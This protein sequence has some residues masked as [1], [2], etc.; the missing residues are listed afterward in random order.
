MIPD[1]PGWEP[2]H[3]LEITLVC[4]PLPLAPARLPPQ[5]SPP[6]LGLVV[7]VKEED[8][9]R[10]V[11]VPPPASHRQGNDALIL[12]EGRKEWDGMEAFKI[13]NNRW[14]MKILAHKRECGTFFGLGASNVLWLT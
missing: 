14:Q 2:L 1:L 5:P 3:C 12:K 9:A 10:L 13:L 6:S 4:L 7:V 8:E 11:V